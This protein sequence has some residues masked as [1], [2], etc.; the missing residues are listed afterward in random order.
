MSMVSVCRCPGTV[1][2]G[3]ATEVNKSPDLDEDDNTAKVQVTGVTDDSQRHSDDDAEQRSDD[4]DAPGQQHGCSSWDKRNYLWPVWTFVLVVVFTSF[5]LFCRH[6]HE[7]HYL[8][9]FDALRVVYY[10]TGLVAVVWGFSL[11]TQFSS[12]RPSYGTSTLLLIAST[13]VISVYTVFRVIPQALFLVDSY[14]RHPANHSHDFT[15]HVAYNSCVVPLQNETTDPFFKF[16]ANTCCT[17]VPLTWISLFEIG[18]YCLQIYT[19]TSFVIHI[20]QLAPCKNDALTKPEFMLFRSIIISLVLWNIDDWKDVSFPS[21]LHDFDDDCLHQYYLDYD[22]WQFIDDVVFPII[23]FYRFQSFS[24]L[25][26]Y[27]VKYWHRPGDNTI[28]DFQFRLYEML[29]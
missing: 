17:T 27:L 25:V 23:A 8:L 21:L 4:A 9:A 12:C 24:M 5:S 28:V 18:I 15:N 1:D 3:T 19:Q 13:F 14:A 6:T 7:R 26:V 16:H 29:V 22:I 10:F 11:A 2:P 20:F